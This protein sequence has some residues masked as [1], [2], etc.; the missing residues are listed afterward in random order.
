MK[1][2]ILALGFFCSFAFAQETVE[3]IKKQIRAVEE[4]TKRENA[5]H[6]AEKKR[7][8]DFIAA[9]REKVVSL[10][11]QMKAVRAEIDS[12]KAEIGRLA[13]AR[14]KAASTA[15]W[16]EG[17]KTKYQND[18]AKF[19]ETLVP[20]LDADF[21]YRSDEAVQSLKEVAEQLKKGVIN[22]DD[23][24]GRAL[25]LFSERIRLGY[26]TETWKGVLAYE[27]RQI[28]GSFL[29]YGAV[30]MVF[31]S[32][33]GNDVLWLARTEDG[34][35]W[36]NVS[37]DMEMRALL[38]EAMKVAEGKTAP[39]LVLLPISL[40]TAPVVESKAPAAKQAAKAAPKKA[41]KPVA[42]AAKEAE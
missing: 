6:E 37:G 30:S 13:E 23:A 35:A 9:G 11:N 25:E 33:D 29:R 24:L 41:A 8:A 39:K 4:E 42:P 14:N 32:T 36:Q 19:L 10:N 18:L 2:L 22:S 38:K 3:S 28:S 20:M 12:M 34:Y 15:H 7:H 21:P 27:N 26:T 5:L 40:Y 17:K 31:V 1:L 16:Y